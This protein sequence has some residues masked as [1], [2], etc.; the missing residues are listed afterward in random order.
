MNLTSEER[1]TLISLCAD[2]RTTAYAFSDD[3]TMQRKLERAG[4]VITKVHP[5][6]GKEYRLEAR[7]ISIR[8]IAAKRNMTPEQ[9]ANA[10]ERMK[11]MQEAKKK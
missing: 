7:Q 6:G 11:K 8:K 1:E 10:R 9:K 5:S 4:A 2:D 3:P